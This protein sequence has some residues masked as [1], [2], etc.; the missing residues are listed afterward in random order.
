M[1]AARP[2]PAAPAIPSMVRGRVQSPGRNVT[3]N[4]PASTITPSTAVWST[5][6]GRKRETSEITS[7]RTDSSSPSFTAPRTMAGT[8]VRSWSA[9]SST[10]ECMPSPGK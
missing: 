8:S 3:A 9:R 2:M 4:S 5:P 10:A 1:A 7:T 6:F